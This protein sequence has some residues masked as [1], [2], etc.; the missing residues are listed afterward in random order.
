MIWSCSST[1]SCSPPSSS[2]TCSC[3]LT[4]NCSQACSCFPGSCSMICS[5]HLRSCWIAGSCSPGSYFPG[6]CF[7]DSCSPDRCC[8]GSRSPGSCS[9][10]RPRWWS[11][12]APQLSGWP[13]GRAARFP[14]TGDQHA[15]LLFQPKRRLPHKNKVYDIPI[16]QIKFTGN[17]IFF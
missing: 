14:H 6:S 13:L 12:D 7:P 8:S 2:L 5:H 16:F 1:C 15:P 17:N 3:L 9:F 11:G 10:L 4:C